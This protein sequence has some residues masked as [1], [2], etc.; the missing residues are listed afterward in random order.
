MTGPRIPPLPEEG[1]DP[2]TQ[3]LL[4]G[5][6]FRPDEPHLNIFLTLAHHPRLLKRWSAFG[7]VLL[8]TGTLSG[9][10]REVLILRTAANTGADYEWGVH[11]AAYAEKAGLGP[12]QLASLAGGLPEDPCWT[13]PV[14]LAV[15]GAVDAPHTHQDLDEAPWAAQTRWPSLLL[16]N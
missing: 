1:R 5:L 14:D 3:E 6:R 12:A 2:R 9:R 11:V 16:R 7:G 8:A 10:D 13:D 4:D 15:I